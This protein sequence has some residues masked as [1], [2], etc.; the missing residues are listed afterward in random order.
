MTH[1]CNYA[2]EYCQVCEAEADSETERLVRS[3]RGRW[4]V[5]DENGWAGRYKSKAQARRVVRNH[6]EHGIRAH[7]RRWHRNLVKY[8]G[9]SF[10]ITDYRWLP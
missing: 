8:A 2:L 9:G 10:A 1:V 4:M 6:E 5:V 7:L 3:Q